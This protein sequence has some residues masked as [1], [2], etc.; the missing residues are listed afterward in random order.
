VAFPGAC[1]IA[2]CCFFADVSILGIGIDE[3][4]TGSPGATGV[5]L[6][7]FLGLP[8]QILNLTRMIESQHKN[9]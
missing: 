2:V 5:L 3:I 6:L 7:V 8:N 4:G 1:Q 9:H